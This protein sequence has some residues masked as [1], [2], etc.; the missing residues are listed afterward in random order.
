MVVFIY[1]FLVAIVFVVASTTTTSVYAGFK[2]DIFLYFL[3][4]STGLM[5]GKVCEQSSLFAIHFCFALIYVMEALYPML[6]LIYII[7][8]QELKECFISHH[9]KLQH[10]A[11]GPQRKTQASFSNSHELLNRNQT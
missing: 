3:C 6:C 5:E 9:G 7:K 11:A 10:S 1:F 4:E 2:E 8:F